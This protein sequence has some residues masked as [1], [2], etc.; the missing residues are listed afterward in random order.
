MLVVQIIGQIGSR[1]WIRRIGERI[2]EIVDR[3]PKVLRY[4]RAKTSVR[5]LNDLLD[6]RHGSEGLLAAKLRAHALARE[7]DKPPYTHWDKDHEHV[8]IHN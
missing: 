4:C 2:V 5:V 7:K 3:I 8:C 1:K 6:M